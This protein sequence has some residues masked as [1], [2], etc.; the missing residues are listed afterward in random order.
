M[1]MTCN[2]VHVFEFEGNQELTVA[3]V[4]ICS[5]SNIN[6]PMGSTGIG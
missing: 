2:S 3:T 1:K 4:L 6:I 5:S